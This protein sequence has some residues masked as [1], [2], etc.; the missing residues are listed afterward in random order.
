MA[1]PT[2]KDLTNPFQRVRSMAGISQEALAE[3]LEIQQSGV[4][5]YENNLQFPEP[6]V[7]KRFVA[8]C[9]KRKIRMSMDEVYERL[10]V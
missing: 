1:V 2:F 10:E 3:V 4:S 8:W 5:K 7:A 6:A 9:R